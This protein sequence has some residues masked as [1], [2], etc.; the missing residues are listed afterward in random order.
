VG[1]DWD[2]WLYFKDEALVEALIL[3]EGEDLPRGGGPVPADTRPGGPPPMTWF[4]D[5]SPCDYF[6][7]E[8]AEYL[9]AVA[10]LDDAHPITTG[11][12]GQS[13]YDRLIEFA[14]DP[15]HP[16]AVPITVGV[17]QCE[18]CLY[19]RPVGK[20]NLFIPS[21]STLYVCPELVVHYMSA[22]RYRPPEEFC[23]AV[24]RCADMGSMD[25]MTAFLAVA[26]PLARDE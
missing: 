6:G 7:P 13:V 1:Y 19:D 11:Q 18:L 3:E 21:E 2:A 4:D 17:H 16:P 5:L 14:R 25:Y 24:R 10:W 26:R 12:V 23:D 22:H 9:T 15:W 20:G 8:F